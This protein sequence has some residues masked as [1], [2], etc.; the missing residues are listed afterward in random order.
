MDIKDR[1]KAW[2]QA[3]PE[4]DES[5]EARAKR[6][7]EEKRALIAAEKSE[8]DRKA[9]D[10][11]NAK[12]QGLSDE[13]LFKRAVGEMPDR[14]SA[15]QKKYDERDAPTKRS[16]SETVDGK[17]LSDEQLFLDAFRDV[18]KPEDPGER[19]GGARSK[20]GVSHQKKR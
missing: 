15:I 14:S 12:E 16:E 20:T 2:K 17:R 7:A 3:H 18:P 8:R 9:K 5:P 6:H 4:L 10:R 11:A 13:E 19:K 1:L